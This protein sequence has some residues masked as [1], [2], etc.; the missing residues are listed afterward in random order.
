MSLYHREVVKHDTY[1]LLINVSPLSKI[2]W[3][4]GK[5]VPCC[6]AYIGEKIK[7]DDAICACNW[8]SSFG[9]TAP[10]DVVRPSLSLWIVKIRLRQSITVMQ[11]VGMSHFIKA[12]R[13][14]SNRSN[15]QLRREFAGQ[16]VKIKGIEG[17]VLSTS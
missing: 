9:R 2:L 7:N 16:G 11:S 13:S 8:Y 12:F 14:L 1:G 5:L 3:E 15:N 17:R 6:T 10:W 4:N